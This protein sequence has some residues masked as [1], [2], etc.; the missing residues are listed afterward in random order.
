MKWVCS[1]LLLLALLLGTLLAQPSATE[2]R[3]RFQAVDI[4]IDSRDRP[5]AAYQ[6]EFSVKNGS[7]KVVGIEGGEHPAFKDAPFYDPKAI[8]QER[9]II[10]AFST[11]PT[12]ELP[13]GKTRVATIHVQ[14]GGELEPEFKLRRET[15]ATV[16]GR[17][18]SVE[19]TFE[20][21]KAQ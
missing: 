7:A 11:L 14:I 12:D 9:V 10:A 1:N 13:K 17:K 6:L 4:F 19:A 21:R 3:V 16:N 2:K 20:E 18:V 8:Q 5:L 15:A